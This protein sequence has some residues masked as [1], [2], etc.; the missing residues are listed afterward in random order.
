VTQISGA[1]RTDPA[2]F[3]RT[4]EEFGRHGPVGGIGVSMSATT[5]LGSA[6]ALGT[7]PGK[8]WPIFSG[9]DGSASCDSNRIVKLIGKLQLVHMSGGSGSCESRATTP[10]S[11]SSVAGD[12]PAE[13]VLQLRPTGSSKLSP[14]PYRFEAAGCPLSHRRR[15][16]STS[17]SWPDRNSAIA[18]W[19]SPKTKH[20]PSL[21]PCHNA[22]SSR[23][24]RCRRY[25]SRLRRCKMAAASHRRS[26]DRGARGRR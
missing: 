16:R 3:L 14:K 5:S 19:A 26:G 1:G 22:A 4:G 13:P 6:Y 21:W 11:A 10:P 15:P 8:A 20:F 12:K 23:Q 24:R 17:A 7:A 9:R 2:Q 18:A 25:W